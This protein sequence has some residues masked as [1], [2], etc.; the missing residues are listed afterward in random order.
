[1][2]VHTTTT[3]EQLPDHLAARFN[4]LTERLDALEHE[5][6]HKDE[7]LREPERQLERKDERIADLEAR[8]EK[9]DERIGEPN[10][11]VI[12]LRRRLKQR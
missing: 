11:R 5:L 10:R 1:M 3:S 6:E 2:S 9:Q 12:V 8:L 4:A 7:R